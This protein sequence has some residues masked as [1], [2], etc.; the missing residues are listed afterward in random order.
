MH[1]IPYKVFQLF[2]SGGFGSLLT[3]K[4]GDNAVGRDFWGSGFGFEGWTG[5]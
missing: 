3:T 4:Q 2:G 5:F 1:G